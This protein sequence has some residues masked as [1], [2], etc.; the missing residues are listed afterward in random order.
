MQIVSLLKRTAAEP[1]P[2]A[3]KVV[4]A[5]KSDWP[6][7]Q[8]LRP[9]WLKFSSFHPI[10]SKVQAYR[11]LDAF[12]PALDTGRLVLLPALIGTFRCSCLS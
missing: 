2:S 1:V 5:L 7:K 9:D 12:F 11:G 4:N 6:R 10:R 3:G 8:N